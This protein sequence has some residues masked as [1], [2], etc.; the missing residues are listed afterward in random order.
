MSAQ[1]KTEDRPAKEKGVHYPFG[2]KYMELLDKLIQESRKEIFQ[3]K[4]TS[5]EE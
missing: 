1:V 3:E 4:D 2:N 5:I